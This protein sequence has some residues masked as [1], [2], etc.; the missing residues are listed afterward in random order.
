M[1]SHTSPE[2]YNFSKKLSCLTVQNF[3]NPELKNSNLK[4]SN[5]PLKYEYV[6]VYMHWS[7]YNKLLSEELQKSTGGHHSNNTWWEKYGKL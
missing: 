7:T 6:Q 4:T 1:T 5:L 2:I 3:Q